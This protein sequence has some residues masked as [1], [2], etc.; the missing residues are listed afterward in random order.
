MFVS[1]SGQ[2][3]RRR[4]PSV[5]VAC[6]RCVAVL[7]DEYERTGKEPEKIWTDMGLKP[8]DAEE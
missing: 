8:E 6:L 3:E 5:V 7:V 1:V 2:A 4:N